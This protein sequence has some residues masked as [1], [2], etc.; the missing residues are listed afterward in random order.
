MLHFW[1]V[2]LGEDLI[3]ISKIQLILEWFLKDHVTLK[4]GVMDADIQL[5]HQRTKL[6]LKYIKTEILVVIIFH[7]LT[8]F[9]CIL[10][11]NF[12]VQMSL[13]CV[14]D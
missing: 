4:T 6:H 5:C 8:L 12:K 14:I 3:T 11:Y 1:T 13:F 9:Y 7:N 2:Y 10:S